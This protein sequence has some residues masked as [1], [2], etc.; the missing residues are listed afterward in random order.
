MQALP[1]PP[2]RFR[3]ALQAESNRPVF[4][5]DEDIRG[6]WKKLLPELAGVLPEPYP[7][8][9]P[10]EER[11]LQWGYPVALSDGLRRVNSQLGA[12]IDRETRFR[13]EV[14]GADQ[15]AVTAARERWSASIRML[16]GNALL[17]DYGRGFVEILLLLISAQIQSVLRGV[18]RM[19]RQLRGTSVDG[20]KLK[21]Q[22]AARLCS[23][24]VRAFSMAADEF[25]SLVDSPARPEASPLMGLLFRDPLL[26]VDA[27]PSEVPE[28]LGA[29][30]AGR[31]EGKVEELLK[32]AVAAEVQ[33][34][35]LLRERREI[36]GLL[37]E[38]CP[39]EVEARSFRLLQ[40]GLLR[41]LEASG[42]LLSL[43]LSREQAHLL[44][45]L[46]LHLK[47]VE[48][49][50]RLRKII[51]PIARDEGGRMVLLR[52]RRDIEVA[53][54]TRP[55]DFTMKGIV[56]TTVFRFG[57][58]YDLRDFS[59]VME[60][61]RK[62]GRQAEESALQ[63]M[64][65]FQEKTQGIARR[66]RLR[67]EKF[68]GDGA[69]LTSRRA[70]RALTAALEIQAVYTELRDRGFPFSKGMRVAINAGHYH[71]LPMRSSSSG[72]PEYEF[73]GHSIVELARLSTGKSTREVQQF[74]Q[75][76]IGRGYDAA[77]VE[78]FL[79]PLM[80]VR[81]ERSDG[82]KRPFPAYLDPHGELIN[83]GIV[84]SF[85]FIGEL[86]EELGPIRLAV[87][88]YDAL[89]WL[90][91]DLNEN[92][93][94]GLRF[95]GTARLK[96][97]EPMELVEA[98]RWTHQEAEVLEEKKDLKTLLRRLSRGNSGGA[99]ADTASLPENLVVATYRDDRRKR[100]WILGQ[101]RHSDGVLLH[102]LKIPLEIPEAE[103][104]RPV[105]T[106]LFENRVELAKIYEALL[107]ENSG[108]AIPISRF[109][110][111]NDAVTCFLAAPHR[112]LS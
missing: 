70:S 12:L 30:L 8:Y 58:I 18:P 14:E 3:L 5:S 28:R 48:I 63:F 50:A 37:E 15:R 53:A 75:M 101:Y 73:F 89:R 100:N 33:L 94:V 36:R 95:L 69:F 88:S 66:R 82:I 40:P 9:D 79:R 38:A 22:L 27:S 7:V 87:G 49:V 32:A 92:I 93:S 25:R 60:E 110:S 54:S 83:E 23:M 91:L 72:R 108:R 107:R 2:D 97:L 62:Q 80:E 16:L 42:L 57:L 85:N 56:E 84:L 11:V 74:A 26:L 102:A 29:M 77:R 76:L 55:L 43:G 90:V 59:E 6:G 68:L 41:M 105:E 24:V 65:I 19:V 52:N 61:I 103:A 10:Q 4:L 20:E 111:M 104:Q 112:S 1:L 67:F 81:G 71:L 45:L 46:G 109:K 51:L 35:E 47:A 106:W 98:V 44:R 64:Y 86:E 78:D 21:F 17:N 39:G 13:L 96:G 34:K 99:R 31:F